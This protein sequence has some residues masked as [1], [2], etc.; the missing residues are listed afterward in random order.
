MRRWQPTELAAAILAHQS[1]SFAVL[2]QAVENCRHRGQR[3]FVARQ[4]GRHLLLDQFANLA[5]AQRPARF[6]QHHAASLGESWLATVG[7]AV[8]KFQQFVVQDFI[9]EKIGETDDG[10]L[11]RADAFHHVSSLAHQLAEFFVSLA[12]HFHN[13]R[14]VAA[15]H[16]FVSVAELGATDLHDPILRRGGPDIGGPSR[17]RA[18]SQL[19]YTLLTAGL[20]PCT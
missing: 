6:H 2:D 1:T 12:D 11:D 16:A 19:S 4:D 13:V 17:K 10:L 5:S 20:F 8:D 18:S 7:L 9:A 15:W 14:I 3:I